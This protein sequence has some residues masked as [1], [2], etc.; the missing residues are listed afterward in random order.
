MPFDQFMFV[1]LHMKM[2]RLF[3]YVRNSLCLAII[4]H[5]IDRWEKFISFV[6]LSRF[7]KQLTE[8]VGLWLLILTD[9]ITA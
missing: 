7:G 3:V 2:L 6:D 4:L 1:C 8:N 9:L 5:F